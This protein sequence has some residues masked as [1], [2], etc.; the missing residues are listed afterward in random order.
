L[1]RFE[2]RLIAAA[3][4]AVVADFH[5]A[6]WDVNHPSQQLSVGQEIKYPLLFIKFDS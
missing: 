5:V 4:D 6:V 1:Q 3:Q 2:L